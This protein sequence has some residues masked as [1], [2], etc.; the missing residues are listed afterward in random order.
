MEKNTELKT[1]IAD[2]YKTHG[3]DDS[4]W[5]EA[6]KSAFESFG[7]K[8]PN[9]EDKIEYKE[10]CAELSLTPSDKFKSFINLASKKGDTILRTEVGVTWNRDKST[11]R[12]TSYL[13]SKIKAE[14]LPAEIRKAKVQAVADFHKVIA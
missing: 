6:T 8:D 4:A 11:N 12:I 3:V 9:A 10:I 2:F 5:D 7:K 14:D 13:S 1:A